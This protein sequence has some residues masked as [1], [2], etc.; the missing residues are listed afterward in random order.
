M[1]ILLTKAVVDQFEKAVKD[2]YERDMEAVRGMRVLLERHDSGELG[3]ELRNAISGHSA[4]TMTLPP[5]DPTS[6]AQSLASRVAEVCNE[7]SD[8]QWTMRRMIAYLKQVGFP[9]SQ[10]PEASVSACLGKL[11]RENKLRIVRQGAGSTPSVYQ[12][13]SSDA[14]APGKSE[15]E[16][17]QGVDP[18]EEALDESPN[19]Q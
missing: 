18:L 16:Q 14:T 10:K 1:A 12:W 7:Y 4:P 17:A 15:D 6:V 5:L 13:I 3:D 11:A 2:R 9:L 8:E 19:S